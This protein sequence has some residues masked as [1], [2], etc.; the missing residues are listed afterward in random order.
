MRLP[1]IPL[2]K[3]A[4]QQIALKGHLQSRQ[5]H[6]LKPSSPPSN[7]METYESVT[8]RFGNPKNDSGYLQNALEQ[9]WGKKGAYPS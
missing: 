8:R 9:R 2:Y 7:P 4:A 1:L 3:N 6:R 5:H